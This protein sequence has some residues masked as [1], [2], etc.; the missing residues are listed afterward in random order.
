[1]SK[2][3]ILAHFYPLQDILEQNDI[4]NS[5]VVQFLVDEKLIDLDDYFYK[6]ADEEEKIIL[7][8]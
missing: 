3:E 4:E 6:D 2:V 7:D 5:V 1:M 8:G